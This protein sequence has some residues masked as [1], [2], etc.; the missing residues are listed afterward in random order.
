MLRSF[1]CSHNTLLY[2]FCTKSIEKE[3]SRQN[4]N[5]EAVGSFNSPL[6]CRRTVTEYLILSDG[7]AR[8]F[9]FI[10]PVALDGIHISVLD[11]PNDGGMVGLSVKS[12]ALP[13]VK[14]N[15]TGQGFGR[16]VKPLPTVFEPLNTRRAICKLRNYARINIAAFICT[17][18]HKAGAPFHTASEAVPSPIRLAAHIA[19]L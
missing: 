14:D 4:L 17:P 13:I 15:H 5:R 3:K 2:L 6:I 9:T 19:D 16:A 8:D 12:V 10:V 7:S 1:T 11:I 18:R